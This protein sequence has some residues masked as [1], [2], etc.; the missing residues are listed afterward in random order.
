MLDAR[1]VAARKTISILVL[2][3][4]A[5]LPAREAAA[6]PSGLKYT[7]IVSKFENQSNFGGWLELSTAWSTI[8]TDQL[9]QT[10]RFLVVGESDMREEA[11]GEQAFG[12]TGVTTQGSKTPGRGQMAPAQLLVKGVI[13]D[14]QH[15]A[16]SADRGLSY[17]GIGFGRRDETTEIRATLYVV[18]SSTGMVVASRGIVGVAVDKKRTIRLEYKGAGAN[19]STESNASVKTAMTA[20]IKDG[21]EWLAGQLGAI[22]WRGSVVLV[23]GAT[24]Y[25]DRGA[26]EGVTEGMALAVGE[27]KLI[28]SPETGEVLDEIVTELAKLRVLRVRDKV[29][30]CEVTEGDATT[31]YTGMG[32]SP[33][34]L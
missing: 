17:K 23:E 22:P 28:R 29:S 19:E 31:I 5:L 21:V 20:A 26:R 9:N 10:G 27:S 32:V 15:S 13:T 16:T 33:V 7:I 34:S 30:I 4:A 3:A 6:Q 25:V 8:L 11:M 24:I 14:Y 1:F 2:V 18:D 12:A